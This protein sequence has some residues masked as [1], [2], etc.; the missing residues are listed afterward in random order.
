MQ[1]LHFTLAASG[2]LPPVL[3]ML[4]L[5]LH[6]LHKAVQGKRKER[7]WVTDGQEAQG[8]AQ[9]PDSGN[10]QANITFFAGTLVLQEL[11]VHCDSLPGSKLCKRPARARAVL[12]HFQKSESWTNCFSELSRLQLLSKPDGFNQSTFHHCH[13][14][15]SFTCSPLHF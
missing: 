10:R 3:E 12:V 9:L 11:A 4:Q 14:D 6:I 8:L 13:Q 5:P 1:T 7:S 2:C 15:K